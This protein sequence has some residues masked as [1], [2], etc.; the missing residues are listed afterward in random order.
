VKSSDKSSEGS[1]NLLLEGI[2]ILSLVDG[3]FPML[4]RA[5]KLGEK[6][7]ERAGKSP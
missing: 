2:F 1:K 6:A 5:P 7:P 4:L 3:I